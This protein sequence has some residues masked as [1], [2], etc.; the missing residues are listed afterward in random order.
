MSSDIVFYPHLPGGGS[1][2]YVSE[3]ELYVV[4]GYPT[5]E[6]AQG[7]YQNYVYSLHDGG[8]PD[9]AAY[10]KFYKQRV[11]GVWTRLL[12]QPKNL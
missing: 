10:V 1:W 5:E 9:F 6:A 12:E 7:G 3:S 4:A 2:G 8:D 11:D